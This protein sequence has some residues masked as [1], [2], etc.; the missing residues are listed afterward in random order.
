MVDRPRKSN[1]PVLRLV[2]LSA[3][4][5]LFTARFFIGTRTRGAETLWDMFLALAVCGVLVFFLLTVPASKAKKV[6]EA[7]RVARPDAVV[8]GNLLGRRG[9]RLFSSSRP[10]REACPCPGRPHPAHRR[11]AR[12]RIATASGEVLFRANPLESCEKHTARRVEVSFGF[13]AQ[14]RLRDQREHHT[15]RGPL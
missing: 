2:L 6:A 9:H 11:L 10:A 14:I 4:A 8:V 15:V 3:M 7:L 12:D 5:V 1:V 13:K